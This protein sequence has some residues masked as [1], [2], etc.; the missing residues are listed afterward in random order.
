MES[1]MLLAMAF[2]HFVA[3]CNPLRY[4]IVLT[5]SP[6]PQMGLAAV[7]RGVALMI[8]LPILLQQLPFCRNIVLS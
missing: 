5:P 4:I 1:A 6:I 2:D 3:I 7:A 8:P